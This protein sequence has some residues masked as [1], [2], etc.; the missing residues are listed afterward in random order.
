MS[1]PGRLARCRVPMVHNTMRWMVTVTYCALTLSHHHTP[2][3]GHAKGMP[4]N[5]TWRVLTQAPIMSVSSTSPKT[6]RKPCSRGEWAST[7]ISKMEGVGRFCLSKERRRKRALKLGWIETSMTAHG[8]PCLHNH[9]DL[10]RHDARA[11]VNVAPRV[12]GAQ[13]VA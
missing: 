9:V 10:C 1:A 5:A 13:L 12:T 11:D 4:R 3:C 8:L 7:H 6:H 2:H